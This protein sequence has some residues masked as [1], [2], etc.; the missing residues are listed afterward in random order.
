MAAPIHEEVAEPLIHLGWEGPEQV[1]IDANALATGRTCVIGAS[2]SGKSY[3]VGVI[4]EELC[5]NQVPFAIVDTEGEHHSLKDKYEVV[6]VGDEEKCDL[7][8]SSVDLAQLAAQAPDIAPLVL[9][10]SETEE[11]RQKVGDLISGIYREVEK[12]RTPYLI[13]VEEADRF[14]PQNGERIAIF[15]EIARRGRKRGV[16]LMVCTQRPSMVDKN[17]LSQCGNQ[18]IGKLVIKNDLQAVAQFFQGHELPKHLTTL[19]PGRFF[20]MGGLSTVPRSVTIRQ[21]ETQHRGSTPRLGARTVR[22]VRLGVAPAMGEGV[23]GAKKVVG[24]VIGFSP[25]FREEDI[26]EMVKRDKSFVFFGKEEVVTNAQLVFREMAE[27]GVAIKAGVLKKRVEMRYLVLDGKTGGFVE[28][29]NVPVLYEGFERLIGL[30]SDEI[31]VLRTTKLDR[32]MSMLE[33]ANKVGVS[34]EMV[35]RPM[36]ALEERRLVR[37]SQVGK[38]RVFRRVF[39]APQFRWHQTEQALEPVEVSKAKTEPSKLDEEKVREVIKGVV[40][41][42]DVQ[43]YRQFIYPFYRVELV[44]KRRKRV[45]WLDGRTA[46]E[47]HP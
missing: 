34:K 42:S 11:P 29:G 46:K 35:R 44:M 14:I 12:R 18:V 39:S 32:E 38:I 33:I 8:W 26:P 43:S 6:W 13:I 41:Y 24:G 31:E 30:G 25:T 27:V 17:I 9:D 47:I 5:K 4:C 2:G 36:K 22:P 19:P 40:P 23:K 10:L 7:Q 1:D 28:L 15:G 20:V 21:K 45:V 3:A 37:S 16:G